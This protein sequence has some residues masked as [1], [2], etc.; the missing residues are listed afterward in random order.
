MRAEQL[1][2]LVMPALRSPCQSVAH[3]SASATNASAPRSRYKLTSS[4]RPQRQAQFP[5]LLAAW[6]GVRVA[7]RK[8]V[9][10]QSAGTHESG[11]L[12]PFRGHISAPN[13]SVQFT[14]AGVFGKCDVRESELSRLPRRRRE[15]AHARVSRCRGMPR[16]GGDSGRRS[17][18]AGDKNVLKA[19]CRPELSR[20]GPTTPK[21]F[22]ERDCQIHWP[23]PLTADREK[24]WPASPEVKRRSK[25]ISSGSRRRKG[26]SREF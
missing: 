22:D 7:N 9:R 19:S 11:G 14:R 21:Q 4:M 17:P 5:R 13:A 18:D 12:S 15:R 26:R 25:P 3:R 1:D 10:W 16:E 8:K 2:N 24:L 6:L 20:F 23:I